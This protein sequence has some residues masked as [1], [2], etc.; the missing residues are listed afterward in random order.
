MEEK[1]RKSLITINSLHIYTQTSTNTTYNPPI[2][3]FPSFPNFLLPFP[4][5]FRSPSCCKNPQETYEIL[6]SRPLFC[7]STFAPL[8]LVPVTG[9]PLCTSSSSMTFH[10]PTFFSRSMGVCLLACTVTLGVWGFVASFCRGLVWASFFGMEG[11][12]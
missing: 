9:R 6:T 2:P 12:A 3:L 10:L 11:T 5:L 1:G 7:T 4:F 8:N